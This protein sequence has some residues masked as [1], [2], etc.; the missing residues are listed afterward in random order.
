MSPS[1]SFLGRFPPW[2]EDYLASR[3]AKAQ[4]ILRVLQRQIALDR[5]LSLLDVGCSQGQI[6]QTL[7]PRF[8]LVVGVDFADEEGRREGFHFVRADGCRLPLRSGTFDVLLLNHVLEHVR[9][10]QLLLD[11]AWRVLRPGGLCYL[12]T[13]NRY[14]LMEQHYRL[15]LLS[16]L[17][18]WLADR[19]VRLAG[20][21]RA[22]LDYPLSYRQLMRLAR[23]FRVRNQTPA[24]LA[25]AA[26]F[27][28]GDPGLKGPAGWLRWFPR[29]SFVLLMPWLPV[30][31]LTLRKEQDSVETPAGEPS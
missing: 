6:T 14:G 17:P 25:D 18:R 16:W 31:I 8:G 2:V 26:F 9:L 28:K 3:E 20:R 5:R 30:Y 13:P 24:V 1:P 29:W 7:A 27:F 15:P 21:G 4:K 10:P 12:A 23:R 19:Y 11:E 22:Y